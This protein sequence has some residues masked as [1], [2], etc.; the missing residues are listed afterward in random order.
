MSEGRERRRG[1]T[2]QQLLGDHHEQGATGEEVD[3]QV[4][5]WG[6]ASEETRREVTWRQL[7]GDRHEQGAAGKEV[8]GEM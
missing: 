3:E 2:W 1:V 7:L 5:G 6:D 8:D 4:Q